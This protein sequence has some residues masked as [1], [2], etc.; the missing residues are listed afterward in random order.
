MDGQLTFEDFKKEVLEDYRICVLSRQLS[1]TGRKEVQ[2]GYAGSGVFGDGKEVAQVALAK[3]FMKGDWRSGY[4]HDQTFMLAAGLLTPEEFFSLLY[5]DTDLRN[6]P[7][8][9]GRSVNNHF[10]T[11]NIDEKGNWLDL[12]AQKN[13]SAD[14]KSVAGQMLRLLGIAFASKCYRNN[15]K[16]YPDNKFSVGGNEVAFGTISATETSDGNFLEAINAASVLQIPMIVAIWDDSFKNDKAVQCIPEGVPAHRVKGWDY[17]ALVKTFGEGIDKARKEHIPVLFHVEE[18]TQPLGHSA[19]GRSEPFKNHERQKRDE[20]NDGIKKFR[21]WIIG[22]GIAT[23]DD[24]KKTEDAAIARTRD[25]Q[26]RAWDDYII[27]IRLLRDDLI[28]VIGSRKCICRKEHIDKVGIISLELKKIPNPTRKDIF[29]AAKKILRHVCVD[30]PVRQR[31]QPDLHDWM[32]RNYGEAGNLY[33]SHLH[34][35]NDRS[36]MNVKEVKSVLSR[37]MVEGGEILLDNWDLLFTKNPGIVILGKDVNYTHEGLLKKYGVSRIIDTAMPGRTI[38]G[39]GTG[40]ALRGLR[41]VIDI[42]DSDNLISVLQTMSDDLATQIYRTA[43][44]Q[45]AP[46]IIAT[47]GHRL[48]GIMN[49][50]LH[51]GMIINS[52]RGI[53]VCVPRNMTQTAG[54][55]NTLLEADDPAIIIEPLN[56][57]RIKE[58]RPSNPGEYRVPLGVPEIL[59]EGSDVTLVTYGACVRIAQEAVAQLK[60]LNISVELIDVQTLL[61]FDRNNIILQSVKKTNKIAFFD[62]DVPGGAT[63]YMMQKVLEGQQAWKYLDYTPVTLTGKGHRPACGTDGNYFSYPNAENVFGCIYGMMHEYNPAKYPQI[64]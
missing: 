56:G 49:S 10:S 64:F 31:L 45:K 15:I 44:R 50:R 42:H 39:L 47:R 32:E 40:I 23:E 57:G 63:A 27:P 48:Q 54:F 13:S 30:C 33:D 58:Y 36:A 5:S 1:I 41:P 6:N 29:G 2:A 8:N 26:K 52:I 16:P 59:N 9:G 22:K 38:T 34:A 12:T 62:E 21:E 60:E 20:E 18:L 35:E 46:V 37:E 55:Y 53:Y 4:Y 19:S 51:Q 17:A 7:H 24:L 28:S 11:H 43:G 25:A 3:Y 61:P 14:F